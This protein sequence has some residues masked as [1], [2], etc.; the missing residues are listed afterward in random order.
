MKL[1]K[2]IMTKDFVFMSAPL[3]DTT[4]GV[5]RKLCYKYGADLT[6]TEMTRIESLARNN[7]ST[8]AKIE[9]PDNT[10]AQIQIVGS[11]EMSL[12]R[13]LSKYEPVNGFAGFN[14][15]LGC[16]SPH[17]VGQGFGCAMI[18]RIS[19]V[20]KLVALVKDR[21][22]PCSIKMRLGL[23]NYEKERKV[24]LN[25]I[26]AID[27]DFFIIHAR[28]GAQH[29][30]ESADYSIFKE[31]VKLGK[32]IIANGD[33]EKKEQID[34]LKSIGVKGAMIGRA[35]VRDIA[36][37]DRLKG[38]IAPNVEELRLEYSAL[39]IEMNSRFKYRENVLKRLGK[40][41]FKEDSQELG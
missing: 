24:Y 34:F 39:A 41:I 36:I 15:N 22:H 13:F 33:I 21:G 9:I 29:Y 3:E 14:F 2:E 27:A 19:K 35:A 31:C 28:H 5:F 4:D 1:L 12:K 38:N 25:L 18:K 26:D 16:P 32:P 20:R 6:F 11:N 40:P 17:I 10:P 37:F 7:Q 23:N 8:W 30:E